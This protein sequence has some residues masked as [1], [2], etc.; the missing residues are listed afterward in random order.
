MT[1]KETQE[2]L[3]STFFDKAQSYLDQK[4]WQKD[5]KDLEPEAKRNAYIFLAESLHGASPNP[6]EPNWNDFGFCTCDS[7]G[8]EGERGAVPKTTTW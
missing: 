6:L 7:K 1:T 8:K 2:R 4:D 5:P 3:I